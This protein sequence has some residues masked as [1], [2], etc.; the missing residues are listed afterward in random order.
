MLGL[1]A[2]SQSLPLVANAPAAAQYLTY[3]NVA[4][5]TSALDGGTSEPAPMNDR[6]ASSHYLNMVSRAGIW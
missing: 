5:Q 6:E 3:R 1:L 2:Y 4:S